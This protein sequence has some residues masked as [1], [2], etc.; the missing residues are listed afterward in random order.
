MVD[1][2]EMIQENEDILFLTA[3]IAPCGPK[4]AFP[5]ITGQ[6]KGK[7]DYKFMFDAHAHAHFAI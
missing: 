5:G 3:R 6:K 4:K 1:H 7:I 2:D